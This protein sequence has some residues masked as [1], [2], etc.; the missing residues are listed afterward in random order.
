YGDR[1]CRARFCLEDRDLTNL[2]I[3]STVTFEACDTLTAG[4]GVQLLAPADVTLRA[5]DEVILR[6]GFSLGTGAR[7]TVVIDPS[8]PLN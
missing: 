2:V 8:I 7:L 5:G 1:I 6:H 3:S 4:A